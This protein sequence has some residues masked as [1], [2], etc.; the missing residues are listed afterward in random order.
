MHRIRPICNPITK[1]ARIAIYPPRSAWNSLRTFASNATASTAHPSFD[2]EYHPPNNFPMTTA[3]K[4]FFSQPHFAIVGASKDETKFGTKI[5]KWYQQRELDITPVHPKESE[6]QGVTTVRTLADLPDAAHTGV[7]IVTPP[8]VTLDLLEALTDDTP[9]E[10]RVPYAWIQT[11]AENEAVY[12][13][14]VDHHLEDRVVLGGPC[15]LADGD[16]VRASLPSRL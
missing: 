1:Q 3:Q 14:I 11:G 8:K 2:D 15:V 7:S 9:I 4:A 6:L 10:K 13:F 16:N 5:L 12:K